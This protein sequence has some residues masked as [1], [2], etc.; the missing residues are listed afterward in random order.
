MNWEDPDI[1]LP[2]IQSVLRHLS[3]DDL[4]RNT[5]GKIAR[6]GVAMSV[7]W[8]SERTKVNCT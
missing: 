1:D 8:K 5:I 6:R 7:M 3:T 2:N 4:S